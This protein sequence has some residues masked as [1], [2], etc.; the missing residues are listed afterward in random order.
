[1]AGTETFQ[2]A[3]GASCSTQQWVLE[4]AA[5]ACDRLLEAVFRRINHANAIGV[6]ADVM[7]LYTWCHEF[8]HALGLDHNSS[9]TGPDYTCMVSGAGSTATHI[10]NWWAHGATGYYKNDEYKYVSKNY[11]G[12]GGERNCSGTCNPL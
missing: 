3:R 8:G 4:Y 2:H 9:T 1:M 7:E 6:D 5:R 11:N 10:N 12:G